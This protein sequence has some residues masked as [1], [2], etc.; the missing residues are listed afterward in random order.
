MTT[1]LPILFD[2]YWMK[3]KDRK[4]CFCD[5]YLQ[6][7]IQD[8]FIVYCSVYRGYLFIYQDDVYANGNGLYKSCVPIDHIQ[9][10]WAPN[11]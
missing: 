7:I 9:N 11:N 5:D 4:S 1:N 6:S 10:Y 8:N 2:Y 3:H